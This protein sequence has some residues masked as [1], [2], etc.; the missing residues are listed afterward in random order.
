[1]IRNYYT[2]KL[3]ANSVNKYKGYRIVESFTQD[4]GSL[5]I[6]LSDKINEIPI[7]FIGDGKNDSVYLKH[8]F[9]RANKNTLDLMDTI[10]DEVIQSV[11]VINNNR[12]IKIEL[13]NTIVY[14][15][16]FGGINSNVF[17]VNKDNT[18]IDAFTNKEKYIGK[19]YEI[20]KNPI[21][22]FKQFQGSV[23]LVDALAKSEFQFGKIYSEE[24]LNRINI[25]PKQLIGN[26]E[27]SE[28][29]HINQYAQKF[30]LNLSNSKKYYIY[31]KSEKEYI[32]SLAEL[33]KYKL[34]DTYNDIN[35]AVRK[36]IIYESKSDN[37]YPLY[38]Q[39]KS[40]IEKLYKKY[41]NQKEAFSNIDNSLD[42]IKKYQKYAEVLSAYH[43]PN[44]TG[45]DIINLS[46]W[47]GKVYEI[48]LDSKLPII[49]NSEK[50]FDK[51]RKGKEEIEIRKKRLPE[52]ENMLSKSYDALKDLSE[53]NT[54]KELEKFK[55]KYKKILGL[56][57]QNEPKQAEDKFRTFDLGDNYTLYVGKNA[58][59]NDELTMKFA[60]PN[61]MWLHARGSSGSH[62]V[63]RL[64]KD[65]KPPKYIMEKA[66]GIC[67]YYSGQKNAGLAPVAYTLKK[68]VR[69]PKGANPGSVVI[70]KEKVIMVKPGLPE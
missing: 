48:A 63:L 64:N 20:S 51:V 5:I 45:K 36:K 58:K 60:K 53:I 34:I 22:N 24:L 2:L 3:I 68:Y 57:M 30:A 56:Q 41:S 16:L 7:E 15:Q 42:R 70:S 18:I 25:N 29:N 26:T 8:N 44:E 67:A 40:Q 4:K 9:K 35:T 1:M 54:L 38:N 69:K 11:S 17:A 23:K 19:K 50:Y 59:N 37:F 52:I 21:K 43:N 14:F 27:Q 13:I 31:K 12:I 32:L 61:D 33:S 66:G 6:Y 55:N 47:E 39:L 62:A 46:D 28:L 49:K 10:L 65:E